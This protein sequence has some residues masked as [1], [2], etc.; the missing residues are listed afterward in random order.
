MAEGSTALDANQKGYAH[1]R[2]ELVLGEALQRRNLSAEVLPSEIG[3]FHRIRYNIPPPQPLVSIIIP[4]RDHA[5]LLENCVGG[6]INNTSYE[7]WEILIIDNGSTS[8]ATFEYFDKISGGNV[9]IHRFPGKF[10]Y[11]AINN[12]GV[13]QARGDIILLLN[14]DVEVID[15]SWLEELVSHT[16]RPEIGAVGCRLYYPDDYVQHDGIV[17]GIGGVAGYA[18]PRLARSGIA[19]F[20]GS[21]II[22]NFSAVTAAALAVR[23]AVFIEVG[24]L[25]EINLAVAFNDVDFCLR[26]QEAGYRNIYTPYAELYHYESISRGP[27]V[28]SEKAARFEKEALHMKDKWD[29]LIDN[30]PCYNPNL[31]LAH[32]FALDM[33]RGQAWPWQK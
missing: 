29:K 21:R 11:S 10:N 22:R 19:E 5:E 13:K 14:N 16:I 17:V 27:D 3:P 30:D 18:N 32:G 15:S 20:G 25:D 31:S 33:D 28:G 23:K 6:I 24:G 9:N 4:T 7:N 2:A 1:G 8:T 12:F 26:I